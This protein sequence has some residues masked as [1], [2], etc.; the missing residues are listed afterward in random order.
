[1]ISVAKEQ[2]LAY[3][4]SIILCIDHD[5]MNQIYVLDRY[6][7]KYYVLSEASEEVVAELVHGQKVVFEYDEQGKTKSSVGAYLGHSVDTD[8]D[9]VFVRTLIG[10]E[11]EY[12]DEQHQKALS[13]FPSFKKQ[14]REKFKGSIP[15][16]ARYHIFSRQTYFYFYSEERYNF[17]DFVR[18]FQREVGTALFFYQIGARDAMR[19]SPATDHIAWCNGLNLCCKSTRELPSVDIEMVILQH[20]EGR[21]IERLKGRCGKLKCSLIYEV[22]TYIEESKNFPAKWQKVEVTHKSC[23][24]CEGV[25]TSFNINTRDVVIKLDKGGTYRLAIDDV[26]RSIEEKKKLETDRQ[27]QSQRERR[28]WQKR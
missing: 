8:R 9:G 1:V 20:L 16:T 26:I 13:H 12:F 11:K 5:L 15:V 4:W 7:S 2:G 27:K 24:N 19:I 17:G 10:K 18:N 21:D 6:T 14:F 23:E 3:D 28:R 25:C 22:E